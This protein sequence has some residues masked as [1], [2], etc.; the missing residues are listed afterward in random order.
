LFS[1][2]QLVT[3]LPDLLFALFT[4]VTGAFGVALC[5][6]GYLVLKTQHTLRQRLLKVFCCYQQVVITGKGFQCL[7]VCWLWLVF[8]IGRFYLFPCCCS[9]LQLLPSI[10]VSIVSAKQE[11]QTRTRTHRHTVT[12]KTKQSNKNKNN[13]KEQTNKNCLKI[14]SIMYF[15][16]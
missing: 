1:G 2:D 15:N 12:H 7:F 6:V 14:N 5:V 11:N 9:V 16:D 13:A 8:C 4:A 10:F 3:W